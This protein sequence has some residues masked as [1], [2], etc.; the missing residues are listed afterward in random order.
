VRKSD[1]DGDGDVGFTDF[2]LFAQSFG[3]EDEVFD[4]DSDGFVG[5]SDFL[6]FAGAFGRV[7]KG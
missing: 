3:S 6:A 5:F 1:F 4:L 2:L 7:V